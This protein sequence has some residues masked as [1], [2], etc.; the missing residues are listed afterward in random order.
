MRTEKEIRKL[1]KNPDNLDIYSE[2]RTLG[3]RKVRRYWIRRILRWV[4]EEE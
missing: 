4:L 3:A 1:Y 2:G